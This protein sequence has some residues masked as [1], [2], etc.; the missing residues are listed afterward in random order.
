MASKQPRNLREAL[1]EKITTKEE[2]FL[3]TSF[4][5]IGDIAV[6]QVHEKLLKKA[7][8]IGEALLSVNK[9]FRTVCMVSGEH[10]GPYRIQ[11]VK[12]IA[13]KNNKTAA[14]K[15]SKCTFMVHL[16]KVFFSPRLGTERL[17]IAG[18]IKK[19]EV[20]GAFFAGVGPFPIVFAK[21]TG[22]KKA[23][24]I[25]LNPEAYDGM[26]HNISLNKCQD[27]I[28]PIL[29]DV[30]KVVP[31][32]LAS[33]CDR[34]VMPLPK[35]G[36]NFLKEAMQALKPKGGIVHFY[37]FVERDKGAEQALKEIRAAAKETRMTTRI[38]RKE[39]VRSFS[40]KIQ[41]IVI[42]FKAKEKTLK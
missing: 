40:P 21:Q 4:D 3:I 17:R 1:K 33:K 11:P 13:G 41:Q 15:E 18:L 27:K 25:E 5:S 14:Y 30:K 36:E 10:Q 20:I 23:Y 31:K 7:R 32:K 9:Q 35:G 39:K 34:V 6:I 24:A 16:G 19:N 8:A 2:P 28:E 38:L 37:R 22:M 29:G 12:V 42:D 26:L